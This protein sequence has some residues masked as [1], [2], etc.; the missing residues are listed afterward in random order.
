MQSVDSDDDIDD[1]VRAGPFS[2]NSSD[3]G[4]VKGANSDTTG[5][6]TRRF[7]KAHAGLYPFLL[8]IVKD[9]TLALPPSLY[10]A[11]TLLARLVPTHGYVCMYIYV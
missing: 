6:S 3:E 11:L 5:I 2:T 10:P 1:S 7:F 9:P 8:E 4:P